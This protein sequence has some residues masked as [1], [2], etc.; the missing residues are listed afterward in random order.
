MFRGLAELLGDTAPEPCPVLGSP[1]RWVWE[2][3]FETYFS[4]FIEGTEFGV[5][6]AR[7]IA[8]DG[9]I[10]SERPADAHDVTATYRIVSDPPVSRAVAPASGADLP[11]E[12]RPACSR[13]A[14]PRATRRAALFQPGPLSPTSR[15]GPA[16]R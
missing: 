6:E 3:F 15:A 10:P 1:E 2:P 5:D 7:E 11:N 14:G 13:Q 8:I 4:D 9:V 16:G 12:I